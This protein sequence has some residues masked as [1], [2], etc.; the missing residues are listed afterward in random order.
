MDKYNLSTAPQDKTSAN[1]LEPKDYAIE[2]LISH[3]KFYETA[4]DPIKV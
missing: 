4:G 3:L 2:C 1:N